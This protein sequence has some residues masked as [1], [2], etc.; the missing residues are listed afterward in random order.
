MNAECLVVTAG[1]QVFRLTPW[2][3]ALGWVTSFGPAGSK[4]NGVAL[5]SS[6]IH[7]AG[8]VGGQAMYRVYSQQGTLGPSRTLE[9][10]SAR[11]IVSVAHGVYVLHGGLPPN[12]SRFTSDGTRVWVRN[13]ASFTPYTSFQTFSLTAD[14]DSIYV[15]GFVDFSSSHIDVGV[16]ALNA[17]AQETWRRLVPRR[18]SPTSMAATGG[19]LYLGCVIDGLPTTGVAIIKI[20][21]PGTA[22]ALLTNLRI[23]SRQ[24]GPLTAAIA[25]SLEDKLGLGDFAGLEAEVQSLISTGTIDAEQS[26]GLLMPVRDLRRFSGPRR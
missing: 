21:G 16:V 5:A 2:S 8:E 24:G 19:L 3:G 20:T 4:A 11:G 15:G 12:V 7:V 10:L 18:G 13:I 25:A 22:E 17:Y 23:L 1:N 6:S 14:N 9:G 26:E